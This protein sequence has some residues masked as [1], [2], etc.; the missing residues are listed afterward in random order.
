MGE[1]VK[2]K[3]AAHAVCV[4][5]VGS[6]KE[7]LAKTTDAGHTVGSQGTETGVDKP[8]ENRKGRDRCEVH[9]RFD[10]E[11]FAEITRRAEQEKSSIPEQ[12]RLLVEWGLEA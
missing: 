6:S 10:E 11:T 12:V 2:R 3:S 4:V 9:V 7:R 1:P 8:V 5:S